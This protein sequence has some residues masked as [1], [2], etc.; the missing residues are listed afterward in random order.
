MMFLKWIFNISMS[1]ILR[2]WQEE[3]IGFTFLVKSFTLVAKKLSSGLRLPCLKCH[4]CHHTGHLTLSNLLNLSVPMFLF[5]ANENNKFAYF[6]RSWLAEK[7]NAKHLARKSINCSCCFYYYY[8]YYLL[9][10]LPQSMI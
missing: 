5:S 8:F 7:R 9:S 6:T 3:T 4:L 1:L 10:C 2:S